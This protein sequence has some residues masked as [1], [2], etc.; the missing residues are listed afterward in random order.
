MTEN[1]A[2]RA[3]YAGV[4]TPKDRPRFVAKVLRSSDEGAT[5]ETVFEDRRLDHVHSVGWDPVYHRLYLSAGDG[6]WRGQA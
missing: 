5:W 6:A 4:Y 2:S 1:E 3:V